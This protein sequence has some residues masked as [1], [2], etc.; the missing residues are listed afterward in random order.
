MPL[1]G[2]TAPAPA[3]AG[4]RMR[5]AD[6]C[7]CPG[8][9]FPCSGAQFVALLALE[10]HCPLCGLEVAAEAVRPCVDPV[11]KLRGRQR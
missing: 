10:R 9:S 11:G 6:W 4:K 1:M 3:P 8:C 7:E 2:A 5:L